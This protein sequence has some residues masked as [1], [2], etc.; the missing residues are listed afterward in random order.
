MPCRMETVMEAHAAMKGLLE[1]SCQASSK[2]RGPGQRLVDARI[3]ARTV[4]TDMDTVG[5]TKLQA[6]P[7]LALSL[8]F[9]ST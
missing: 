7:A 5:E 4:P 2:L 1:Q 6:C 8:G 3:L 9:E